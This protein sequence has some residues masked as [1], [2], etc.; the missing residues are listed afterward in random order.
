MSRTEKIIEVSF[1]H[2]FVD[3]KYVVNSQIG[4][5]YSSKNHEFK[6]KLLINSVKM[7]EF[8]PQIEKKMK[9]DNRVS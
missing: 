5:S 6:Y 8:L 3:Q 1:W 2:E 4:L 9:K 7:M